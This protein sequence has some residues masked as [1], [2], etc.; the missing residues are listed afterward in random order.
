MFLPSLILTICGLFAFS[1][2]AVC[3]GG[4]GLILI[5]ILKTVVPASQVPAALSV[6]TA[7]SSLSRI[8]VFRSHINWKIV[9]RFV[10]PALPAVW[11]GAWLLKFF[12]PLYLE[13]ILGA[14]LV[15]NLT[16]L[17]K[18][19][20]EPAAARLPM[21]GLS[22]IGAA[23]GFVSGLTGAVGLLFNRFY[24]RY[25]MSKEQIV[26]TRA[27]N[28]ILLH[29][30]KLALYA[31]FGLLT[32]NAVG[33][34]A[35]I[36]SSAIISSWAMKWVLPRISPGLFRRIG[37]IAMVVSGLTLF[38]GAVTRLG[39][40]NVRYISFTPISGGVQT[41]VQWRQGFFTLE[42]EIDEGP[43]VEVKTSLDKLD[44]QKQQIAR[45]LGAGSEK[46]IIE[47]VFGIRKH[48]HELYVFRAGSVEKFNI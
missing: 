23:A 35:L 48:Y 42:F 13:L 1:I 9:A 34:G 28:E 2:S 37:Y 44:A 22:V 27:A 18:K 15:S 4:A 5:P 7:S 39:R 36:A 40:E 16:M 3:G 20:G 26:A 38:G 45:K 25:G 31:S 46:M 29:I 43:E 12:N 21:I 11:L 33:F 8:A 32:A 41:Q 30:I 19:D 24:L 47:E 17:F 14:F 6:G 10:P